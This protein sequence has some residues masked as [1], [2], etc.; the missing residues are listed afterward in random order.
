MLNIVSANAVAQGLAKELQKYNGVKVYDLI[1][2]TL[3][4]SDEN[5]AVITGE[6]ADKVKIVNNDGCL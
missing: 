6:D 1:Q 4:K 3:V 5:K 2:V